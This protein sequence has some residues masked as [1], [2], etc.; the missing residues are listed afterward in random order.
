MV[1]F[2]T[3]NSPSLTITRA[4]MPSISETVTME[5]KPLDQSHDPEVK[6]RTQLPSPRVDVGDFSLW[7]ILRKNI[8]KIPWEPQFNPSVN[9]DS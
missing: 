8:G 4:T 7:T 1:Y 3:A 6:R 2:L 5:T 9:S